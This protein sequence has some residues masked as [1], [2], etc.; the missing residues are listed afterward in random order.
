M[1][2]YLKE[3]SEHYH[4]E[5]GSRDAVRVCESIHLMFS[6]TF[7]QGRVD[8]HRNNLWLTVCPLMPVGQGQLCMPFTDAFV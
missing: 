6:R 8:V 4:S 2:T 3:N 1:D 7:R 5:P